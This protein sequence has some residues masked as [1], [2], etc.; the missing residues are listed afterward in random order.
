MNRI[1]EYLDRYLEET[2]RTSINPVEANAIL[3]E[4]ELLGDDK[5]RPGKPL[6]NRLRKG[7]VPHAYQIG[8]KGSSW[9]IPHSSARTK[10]EPAAGPNKSK[11]GVNIGII[12]AD[13]GNSVS[14]S[15]IN[16]LKKQLENARL[17]YKPVK[18]KYLLIAEAPPDSIERFFYYENVKSHDHLFLGVTEALYP[19][20]KDKYIK[21]RRD[22]KI[23]KRYYYG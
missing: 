20:L 1:I 10:I 12:D 23:K 3:E 18:I 14:D 19:E 15:A 7:L 21:S 6:R 16:D 22:S 2:G 11:S 9:V 5:N 17:K 8:G 4:E 13:S